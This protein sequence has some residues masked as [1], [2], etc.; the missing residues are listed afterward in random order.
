MQIF[1]HFRK[2][3]PE[4]YHLVPI[5]KFLNYITGHHGI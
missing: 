1:E 2:Y 4:M 3:T 5:F